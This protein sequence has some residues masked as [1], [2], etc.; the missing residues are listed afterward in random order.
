MPSQEFEL[1]AEI[2]RLRALLERERLEARRGEEQI[3]F[4]AR[5]LMLFMRR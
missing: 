3:R 5:L 1:E 4:Q 2:S